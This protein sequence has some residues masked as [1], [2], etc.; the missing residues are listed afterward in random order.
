MTSK[1]FPM[2]CTREYIAGFESEADIAKKVLGGLDEAGVPTIV[3][4]KHE[5]TEYW[6]GQCNFKRTDSDPVEFKFQDTQKSL[7]DQ[8][9]FQI[10]IAEAGVRQIVFLDPGGRD[11]WLSVA[12]WSQYRRICILALAH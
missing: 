7:R 1:P 4:M 9:V 10:L 12:E 5:G 8:E 2:Y 3:V 11:S 6:Y